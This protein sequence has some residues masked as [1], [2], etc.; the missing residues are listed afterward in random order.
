MFA[1]SDYRAGVD[2]ARAWLFFYFYFY[3]YFVVVGKIGIVIVV[4]VIFHSLFSTALAAMVDMLQLVLTQ[5]ASS[6]GIATQ[7]R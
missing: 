1:H 3:F 2:W 7:R 5:E 6:F 4:I